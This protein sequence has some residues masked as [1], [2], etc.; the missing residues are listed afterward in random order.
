MER[1]DQHSGEVFKMFGFFPHS[2]PGDC[3]S[4]PNRKTLDVKFHFWAQS[5]LSPAPAMNIKP[6][7]L[8]AALAAFISPLQGHAQNLQALYEEGRALY[9]AGHME[10]A[11]EKLRVVAARNPDHVPTRAMLAQIQQILG[12]DNTTLKNSYDKI[13]IEKIEFDNVALNEA[14]EAVRFYTRKATDQKITP[15]IILKSGDLGNR[16]VSINLS[17]VPL[18]EVLN[19]LAQLSG[20]KLTYD[21][22]AAMFS[23]KPVP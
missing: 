11:R 6:L 13:I 20:T 16:P 2:C 15:N 8:L 5:N 3:L 14:I 23:E 4:A 17:N 12:V 9:N 7:L 19:Y 1:Y 22:N 10:Q 18:T 21:K